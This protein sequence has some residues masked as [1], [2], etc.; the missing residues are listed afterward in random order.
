M[1]IIVR[2]W[3]ELLDLSREIPADLRRRSDRRR[4][5]AY[6]HQEELRRAGASESYIEQQTEFELAL[7]GLTEGFGQACSDAVAGA[8]RAVGYI[9]RAARRP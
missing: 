8:E 5:I 7:A 4:V 9:R 3:R 1:R 6:G 2:L